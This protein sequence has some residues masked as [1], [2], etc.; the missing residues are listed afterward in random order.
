MLNL[1]FIEQK[2]SQVFAKQK[3]DIVLTKQMFDDG[4]ASIIG[5]EVH[6]LGFF[7]IRTI[8]GA[9]GKETYKNYTVNLPV[10]IKLNAFNSSD[11]KEGMVIHY[12]KD[13][14]IIEEASYFK[15]VDAVNKFLNFLVATKIEVKNPEDLIKLFQQNARMNDVKLSSQPVIVEAIISELVRWDKDETKP[16]RLALKDKKVKKTDFNLVS[17]KE[18]SR[19]TSV[20]N[21]ISFEDINKSLQSAVLMSKTNK[22][23]LISPVEKTL[24]Y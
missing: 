23:Q 10:M 6:T 21:A 24:T 3:L 2:E 8:N 16:L 1:D 19:M 11:E 18:I 17:I 14:I 15:R 4:L 20:F 9:E 5:S 7:I 12:E 13:D 22:D